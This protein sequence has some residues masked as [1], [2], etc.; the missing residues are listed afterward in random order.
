[1]Q[2]FYLCKTKMV[3]SVS[4]T[5]NTLLDDLEKFDKSIEVLFIGVEENND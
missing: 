1:M 3:T 5:W 2:I 4:Q